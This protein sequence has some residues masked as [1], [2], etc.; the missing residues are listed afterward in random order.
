MLLHVVTY[1]ILYILYSFH[2]T[3]H[4]GVTASQI[5]K[6]RALLLRYSRPFVRRFQSEGIVYCTA[7]NAPPTPYITNNYGSELTMAKK[8][9][10]V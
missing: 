2:V 6:T 9:W 5:D 7:D 3:L 4:C 1:H 10:K 8:K